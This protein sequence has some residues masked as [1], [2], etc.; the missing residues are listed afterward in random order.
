M[1]VRFYLSYGVKIT[2]KSHFW[3]E[4]VTILSLCTLRCYGRHYITLLNMYYHQ[5]DQICLWEMLKSK[6]LN[7]KHLAGHIKD[8]RAV[9]NRVGLRLA[10]RSVIISANEKRRY[11]KTLEFPT[12]STFSSL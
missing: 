10:A 4:D 2:F 5:M 8:V 12:V 7:Q 9:S 3:N 1:N 11:V 6:T